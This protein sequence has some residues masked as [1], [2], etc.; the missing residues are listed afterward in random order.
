MASV[1]SRPQCVKNNAVHCVQSLS[2][3]N[4]R[5]LLHSRLLVMPG[6]S[7]IQLAG[8]AGCTIAQSNYRFG[9]VSELNYGYTAMHY[10]ILWSVG[11]STAFLRPPTV[12]FHVTPGTPLPAVGSGAN[13]SR[14]FTWGQYHSVGLCRE[15]VKESTISA[16][17]IQS[18]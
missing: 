4:R 9:Y 1:W 16:V 15:T 18:G 7:G 5:R 10:R 3:H 6:L 14:P 17:W 8:V 13:L 12:P 2:Y 11:I